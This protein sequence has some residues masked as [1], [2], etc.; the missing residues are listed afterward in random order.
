MFEFTLCED[1]RVVA[2]PSQ[3]LLDRNDE[4]LS[5][6]RE[7]ISNITHEFG[8]SYSAR[9][10][11]VICQHPFSHGIF[12]YKKGALDAQHGAALVRGLFSLEESQI[13]RLLDKKI[14]VL[15]GHALMPSFDTRGAE[16]KLDERAPNNSEH[17]DQAFAILEQA[18]GE[19]W[20][21]SLLIN[22]ISFVIVPGMPDLPNF[23][24]STNDI[25][26]AMHMTYP[27]SEYVLAESVTHESSHFWVHALE[28]FEELAVD[29]WDKEIWVSAW[30]GDPRPIAG[31]IHGVHVFSCVAVVLTALCSRSGVD[32]IQT[33][34]DRRIARLAYVIA[35][36]E[37]G[38]Y[39]CERS[40]KLRG[41]GEAILANAIGR[42]QRPVKFIGE[43]P[44]ARARSLVSAKR[45]AK[46]KQWRDRGLVVS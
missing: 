21:Q 39:E 19:D 22:T 34:A 20:K 44:M 9:E 17:L 32:L 26:G 27:S 30:R 10:L 16:I 40:K 46:L 33:E 41:G 11:D 2:K 43:A 5:N 36:V 18:L 1:F 6:V 23:S 7:F 13:Q 28:E 14:S 37:D 29:S 3:A 4:R 12:A 8:R 38:I 24:G 31:V 15:Q 25:W 42:L 45:D 35:Q